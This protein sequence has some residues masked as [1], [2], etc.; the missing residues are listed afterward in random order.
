MARPAESAGSN[1][2]AAAAPQQQQTLQHQQLSREGLNSEGS[3]GSTA[4][5]SSGETERCASSP[6][7][8]KVKYRSISSSDVGDR[9][10]AASDSGVD[11]EVLLI[12]PKLRGTIHL[13][14]FL[15]APVWVALLLSAC[16]RL[17]SVFAA[18]IS[19]LSFLTNFAASALLHSG[20]WG[21]QRR[22]LIVKLDHAGLL[23]SLGAALLLIFLAAQ[24]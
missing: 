4:S 8:G 24:P 10:V 18:S 22:S 3:V 23:Y 2:A 6:K 16:K 13:G 9:G 15:M 12:R 14:L 11:E 5:P 1:N 7:T 21:P 19:C 17:I 20:S